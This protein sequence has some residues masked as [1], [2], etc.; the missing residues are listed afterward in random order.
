MKLTLLD[1]TQNILSS[2]NSDEVNSY[3]DTTESRQVAEI[4]RTAYFNIVTRAQL[5]EHKA[6]VG[7]TS[8]LDVTKPTL[9]YRPDNLAK[10]EWIKYD[11][12]D[13]LTP[14][15]PNY[16]L[17]DIL[18]IDQFL[19]M[20]DRFDPDEADIGQYFIDN[21]KFYYKKDRYPSYCTI[22]SDYYVIFDSFD[23]SVDDTLQES[24]SQAYG[25]TAPAFTLADTFI[26]DLDDNQFP[27]LLNEAKSLAFLE[28]KQVAHDK[29]EVEARRHWRTLQHSKHTVKP[30]YFNEFPDF[31]RK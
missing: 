30:N 25:R 15:G 23:I 27:L 4:I 24:K 5:P 28:L 3:S 8:S 26:P 22:L 21:Y 16:Q 18:P 17:V 9:M 31:G 10:I 7:L 6:I 2:L 1:L 19:G 11:I 12:N 14:S 29:A 13:D 20:V